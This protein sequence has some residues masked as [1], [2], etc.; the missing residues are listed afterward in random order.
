MVETEKNFK[1][2]CENEWHKEIELNKFEKC[3]L[4]HSEAYHKAVLR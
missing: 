2:V 1:I 4:C 3:P